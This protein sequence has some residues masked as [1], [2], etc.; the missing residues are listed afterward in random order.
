MHSINID[1]LHYCIVLYI[2]KKKTSIHPKLYIDISIDGPNVLLKY[3]SNELNNKN[4]RII[5]QDINNREDNVNY[6]T[7]FLYEK[8]K[9][10][11]QNLIKFIK[12][13][14]KALEKHEKSGNYDSC[15]V[16][17]SSILLM[18]EFKNSF[19]QWFNE[20]NFKI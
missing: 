1:L 16:V 15:R 5:K 7:L 3:Y 8:N 17:E 13:Q 2:V 4:Q 18:T 6:N 10:E 12:I 19:N 14:K 11:Y 20:N 9:I